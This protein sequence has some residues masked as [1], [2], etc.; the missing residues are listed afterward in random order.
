M[1]L[2]AQP[3]LIA[4]NRGAWRCVSWCGAVGGESGDDGE[5]G[6][7]GE[8][9]CPRDGGGGAVARAGGDGLGDGEGDAGEQC[10]PGPL[11]YPPCGEGAAGV[12]EADVAVADG[13]GSDAVQD[14]AGCE[15]RRDAGGDAQ[16]V[17]GLAV[18]EG[19]GAE[20]GRDGERGGPAGW[21]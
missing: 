5:C 9:G 16:Q 6:A 1:R 19:C 13:G 10:P 17:A 21:S 11:G 3:P 12:D 8:C 14:L 4:M 15:H 18:G 7:C 20:Q 2:P